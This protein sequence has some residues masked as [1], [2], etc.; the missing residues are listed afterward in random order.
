MTLPHES[1]N[2]R[3]ERLDNLRESILHRKVLA[4]GGGCPREQAEKTA[5][6]IRRS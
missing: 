3:R 4:K 2:S 5:L 1:R 6:D